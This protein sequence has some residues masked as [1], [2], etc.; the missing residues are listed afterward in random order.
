MLENWIPEAKFSNQDFASLR[1]AEFHYQQFME[2]TRH[3]KE[4]FCEL[5]FQISLSKFSLFLPQNSTFAWLYREFFNLRLRQF[6]SNRVDYFTKIVHCFKF[7]IGIFNINCLT[8]KLIE[9]NWNLYFSN[10][11]IP[12]SRSA[13][14]LWVVFVTWN[15]G[16]S[17][18]PKTVLN[19]K[20]HHKELLFCIHDAISWHDVGVKNKSLS[21]T[22]FYFTLPTFFWLFM[23]Y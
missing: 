12:T 15:S 22:S 7:T 17:L 6:S 19:Y 9:K 5:Q 14:V 1:N 11:S 13:I 18:V 10:N 23:S 2:L 20:W 4:C 16:L 21:R 3:H 8:L